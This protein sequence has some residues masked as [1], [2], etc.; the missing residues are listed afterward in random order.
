MLGSNKL[1]FSSLIVRM[2]KI[3]GNLFFRYV[4]A[5]DYDFH[6]RLLFDYKDP[7]IIFHV[8]EK[9]A[10]IL[11]EHEGRQSNDPEIV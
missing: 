3:N 10:F 11:R 9:K 4:G 7:E 1:P 8:M 5:E 6:L 2:K